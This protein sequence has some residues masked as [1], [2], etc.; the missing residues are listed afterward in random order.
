LGLS[1][2]RKDGNINGSE[3]IV[4]LLTRLSADFQ[5]CQQTP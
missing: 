1:E 4:Q 3:S 5:R 2:Q